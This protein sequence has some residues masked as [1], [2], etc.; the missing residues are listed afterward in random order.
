MIKIISQGEECILFGKFFP[1]RKERVTAF[2][3]G[4]K[5]ALDLYKSQ[6]RM[7]IFNKG[8]FIRNVIKNFYN[9]RENQEIIIDFLISEINN[10]L[11][12]DNPY[13]YGIVDW[14][15]LYQKLILILAQI[16]W[17]DAKAHSFIL[18][19]IANNKLERLLIEIECYQ[20]EFGDRGRDVI[21]EIILL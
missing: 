9:K 13:T 1:F 4:L 20:K 12:H 18:N 15:P 10:S 16:A 14:K 8:Q 21:I 17:Q 5:E 6:D 2:K 19:F 3:F 11:T 7:R